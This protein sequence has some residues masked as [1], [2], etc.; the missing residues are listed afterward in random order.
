MITLRQFSVLIWAGLIPLLGCQQESN[1][2]A[3]SNADT[4]ASAPPNVIYI[5]TDDL[6]YGD[7]SC[8][9]QQILQTPNID[10]LAAEGMKFTQHYAGATVCSP[11]R[12][13]LMTG[14]HTGHTP[15]RGN[16][17]D[18][19]LLPDSATTLAE[20]FQNAGYRTGF[21]GKWGIGHPPPP[22][23]PAR[24]GF[25]EAY[26]YINMWHAHNCF[27]EFLY[28]NGE[29]VT[30]PGNKLPSPNP[31]GDT[32]PEGTGV[33]EKQV[34]YA[35]EEF[36]T[37]ALQFIET[38]KEQP[39][40]LYLALNIPHAN[41]EGEDDGMEVPDFG[42]YA[43]KDWPKQEKGFAAMMDI[44]D[45]TVGDIQAKL[46]ELGLD[47]NTLVIFT[48]DNGPHEEGGHQADFFDSNGPLRGTKRDLY[49]GGVRIPMIAR[50]PGHISAGTVSDHQSA[51]WDMVPTI[52]ELTGQPVPTNIDGISFLPTLLGTGDQ[53]Q[54]DYLYWEFYELGGRQG[55]RKGDWK[56]VRYNVR[57]GGADTTTELFD[58]SQDL[59]E[60]HNIAKEHPEVVAELEA[61]MEQAHRPLPLV[62]LFENTAE[63][64]TPF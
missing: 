8:F 11:S 30:L 57:E 9:G 4:R 58:L 34:T 33:S 62:S 39:F 14:L 61:L 15:I 12:A 26:G 63:T 59:G 19:Q 17:P 51:F 47:E 16:K 10:R 53:V 49:E 5:L 21:F 42:Q 22:D 18:G 52:C 29:K 3:S 50:W 64:E 31:W 60:T 36:R 20:V 45:G 55:I 48:S 25:D 46:K 7:I 32:R 2:S 28:E 27:P 41:T 24:N 54:H 38:N 1:Q 37:R 56:L 23:D 35:P 6:G 43:D 40:F 13:A 44:I